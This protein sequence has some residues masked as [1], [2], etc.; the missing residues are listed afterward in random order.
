LTTSGKGKKS[1]KREEEDEEAGRREEVKE[2][3]ALGR[4]AVKGQPRPRRNRGR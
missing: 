3:R 2:E 4:A 1:V